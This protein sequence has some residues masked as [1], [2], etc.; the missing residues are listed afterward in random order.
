MPKKNKIRPEMKNVLCRVIKDDLENVELVEVVA[1][2]DDRQKSL[3]NNLTFQMEL[4]MKIKQDNEDYSKQIGT[5]K[6][7]DFEKVLKKR[8]DGAKEKYLTL[9]HDYLLTLKPTSVEAER[10]FSAASYI[11]YTYVVL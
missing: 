11:P 10:V 2:A 8:T 6:E 7:N 1:A 3:Q 5:R 9:T 4:E